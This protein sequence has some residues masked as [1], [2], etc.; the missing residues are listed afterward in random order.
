MVGLYQETAAG[1]LLFDYPWRSLGEAILPK[2]EEQ[3]GVYL[4]S[5]FKL[6]D[7]RLDLKNDIT[8]LLLKR[9]KEFHT[10]EKEKELY[11]RLGKNEEINL[12]EH[13]KDK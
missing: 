12:G 10:E 5:E 3:S 1:K 8:L 2:I 6:I 13:Y 11:K 9:R 7:F 4:F